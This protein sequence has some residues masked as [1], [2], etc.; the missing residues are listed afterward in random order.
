MAAWITLIRTLW[1]AVP[2]KPTVIACLIVWALTSASCVTTGR[3]VRAWAVQRAEAR[4]WREARR[5]CDCDGNGPNDD[6]RRPRPRWIDRLFG[7]PMPE[8]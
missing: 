7:E 8:E 2:A 1:A 4:T 5:V 6:G 3:S